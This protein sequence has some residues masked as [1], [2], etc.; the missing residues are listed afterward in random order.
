MLNMPDDPRLT[1]YALG[2]LDEAD[3]LEVEALIA[4]DPEAV[5]QLA[6]ILATA[7]LLTD[8]LRDETST[9]LDPEQRRAIEERLESPMVAKPRRRRWIRYALAASIVGLAA[10][11]ILTTFRPQAVRRSARVTLAK[12]EVDVPTLYSMAPSSPRT[13]QA[14]PGDFTNLDPSRSSATAPAAEF[15]TRRADRATYADLR[16]P[17]RCEARSQE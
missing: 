9:G 15:E 6:D 17:G 3:R 2:E 8:Q 10:T 13:G 7:R 1:A 16:R 5:R 12:A 4:N 11:L 14:K